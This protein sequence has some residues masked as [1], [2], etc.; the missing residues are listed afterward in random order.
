MYE[1]WFLSIFRLLAYFVPNNIPWKVDVTSISNIKIFHYD[2]TPTWM[3]P[4]VIGFEP[5]QHKM[6]G[7]PNIYQYWYVVCACLRTSGTRF[8][9]L[10]SIVFKMAVIFTP[11]LFSWFCSF[12][13]TNISNINF[14]CYF[15]PNPVHSVHQTWALVIFRLLAHFSPKNI[16]WKVDVTSISNIEIFH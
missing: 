12:G 3:N 2:V 14:S 11:K 5:L 7:C 10:H 13:T 1:R 8:D 4:T 16:P 15:P 9:D 6:K